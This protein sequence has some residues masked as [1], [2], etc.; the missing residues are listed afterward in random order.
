MSRQ[1]VWEAR[2]GLFDE[3]VKVEWRKSEGKVTKEQESEKE[4][5]MINLGWNEFLSESVF[6]NQSTDWL[7]NDT[8]Y[9][10]IDHQLI[11]KWYHRP[12]IQLIDWLINRLIQ[13]SIDWW[14]I[15][16]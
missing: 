7:V 9:W 5:M 10:L 4:W 6:A 1:G 3:G 13:L 16:W 2:G 11:D 14:A 8:I 12:I 15:D